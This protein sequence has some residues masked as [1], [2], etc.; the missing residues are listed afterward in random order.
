MLLLILLWGFTEKSD[1]FRGGG[2]T[3]TKSGQWVG[4]GGWTV[5]RLKGEG[6]LVKKEGVFSL[7]H[8]GRQ[9]A[10]HDITKSDNFQTNINFSGSDCI[11]VEILQKRLSNK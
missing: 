8:F 10:C 1:F 5:S 9:A 7:P 4:G 11:I 2:G 6:G 3:K